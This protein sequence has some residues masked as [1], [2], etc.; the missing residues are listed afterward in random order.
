[1]KPA[2]YYFYCFL[3]LFFCQWACTKSKNEDLVPKHE[4]AFDALTS[5]IKPNIILIVGDDV[6]YEIPTFSGGNSYSTP[7]LDFMAANGIAFNNYYTNPDGPPA[8]LSLLTGKYNIR[9]WER[10]LYIAPEDKTFANLLENY[11][12]K[13][14]MQNLNTQKI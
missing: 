8:R 4:L 1:M 10:F 2:K 14:V 13:T 9:N 6:G 5:S 12:C 3:L 7:S 11:G